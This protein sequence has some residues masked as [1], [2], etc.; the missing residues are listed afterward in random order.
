MKINNAGMWKD[1]DKS[2]EKMLIKIE[3]NIQIIY[4]VFFKNIKSSDNWQ[5]DARIVKKNA[6]IFFPFLQRF[7]SLIFVQMFTIKNINP[8]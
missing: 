7:C 8:K 4:R 5:N 1:R 2:N 3:R 6:T